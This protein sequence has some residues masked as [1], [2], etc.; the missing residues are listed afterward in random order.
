M[1]NKYYQEYLQNEVKPKFRSSLS[2]KSKVVPRYPESAEREFQRLSRQ[3]LRMFKD[4]LKDHL[5]AI[6]EA[7]KK[8]RH[9]S[10]RLDDSQDLNNDVQEEMRKT[11]D[12]YINPRMY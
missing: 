2:I 9:S 1:D 6:M 12:T 7:Y 3:Y 11:A 5:P 8:E 10:T 4:T